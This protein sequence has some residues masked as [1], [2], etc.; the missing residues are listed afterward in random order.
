M[1]IPGFQQRVRADVG[2][3]ANSVPDESVPHA[4]EAVL[5]SGVL[6]EAEILKRFLRYIV[7]QTV[8]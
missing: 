3:A 1:G 2:P 6:R 8:L 4:L 7:E 5:S